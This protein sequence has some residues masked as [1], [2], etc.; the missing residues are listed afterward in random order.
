MSALKEKLDE[1]KYTR[2]DLK[3]DIVA[4]SF[5]GGIFGV[6]YSFYFLS[7]DK[8]D[9]KYVSKYRNSRIIYTAV[10]S[11]K[12]AA[13]FAIMRSAFNALKKQEVSQAYELGGLSAAFLLICT[14]M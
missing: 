3:G 14:F 2:R 12:M 4:G 9:P 13:G 10:N 5:N 1:I 11:M 7:I 8:V 6:V